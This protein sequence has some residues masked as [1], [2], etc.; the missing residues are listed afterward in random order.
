[1][2]F[3]NFTFMLETVTDLLRFLTVHSVYCT[4]VKLWTFVSFFWT[5]AGHTNRTVLV[6]R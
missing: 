1:M 4:C 5:K 3:N 2:Q 6:C